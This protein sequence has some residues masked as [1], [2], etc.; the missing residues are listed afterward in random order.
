[1]IMCQTLYM[2]S[3]ISS[4]CPSSQLLS[5]SWRWGNWGL[6][7]PRKLPCILPTGS[8]DGKSR[9]FWPKSFSDLP[10]KSYCHVNNRYWVPQA[11][12]PV[13]LRGGRW[14][15]FNTVLVLKGFTVCRE[16]MWKELTS[17]LIHPSD[18]HV[19]CLYPLSSPDQWTRSSEMVKTWLLSSRSPESGGTTD[20]SLDA[21]K[22]YTCSEKF[23]RGQWKHGG[24]PEMGG[25]A[26]SHRRPHRGG[27]SGDESWDMSRYVQV[28]WKRYSV[29]D[30]RRC[31]STNPAWQSCK[32][33]WS[34]EGRAPR[35]GTEVSWERFTERETI[36]G[37]GCVLDVGPSPPSRNWELDGAQRVNNDRRNHAAELKR[38]SISPIIRSLCKLKQ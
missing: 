14:Y 25:R 10:G 12:G 20:E 29:P 23:V 24:D 35:W 38:C 2:H 22:F 5:S 6:E 13:N 15:E 17:R 1:M 33:L 28:S 30:R 3:L 31:V 9:N 26:G 18:E 21:Q 32:R 34:L 4:L 16:L 19:L 36:P 11:L 37:W 8:W 27:S 7:R